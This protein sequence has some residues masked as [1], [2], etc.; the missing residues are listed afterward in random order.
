MIIVFKFF[1]LLKSQHSTGDKRSYD[2][3][4]NNTPKEIIQDNQLYDD[5]NRNGTIKKRKSEVFFSF[6][7]LF[8]VSIEQLFINEFLFDIRLES[9]K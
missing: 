3:N 6:F 4:S 9:I 7:F 2:I 8:N 1:R 5:G